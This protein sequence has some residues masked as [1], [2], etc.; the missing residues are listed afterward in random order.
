MKSSKSLFAVVVS[1]L[2]VAAAARAAH[3]DMSDPKRALGR[4]DDV[5]IDAQLIQDTVT[6]GSP[7]G[8]T[9]QVENL[10]QKPI[11]LADKVCDVTYDRDSRTITISIGSE[12]PA[13]G[14][15]PHLTT[16]AAGEKKTFRGGAILHVASPNVRSPFLSVPQYVEIRV[17]VLRDL[18]AFAKLI[19]EQDTIAAPA[20]LSDKQFDQWL[21]SNDTIFLNALPVRYTAPRRGNLGDASERGA[22]AGTY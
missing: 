11:A 12:V 2:F 13:N 17:N 10:S 16:I 1:T 6:S 15:M 18:T 4:E 5:R 3:V 8:V 20:Q 7:V 14:E 22:G 21:D 9:Y 19:G